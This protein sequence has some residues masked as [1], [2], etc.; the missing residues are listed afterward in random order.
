MATVPIV[1]V[2]NEDVGTLI[3]GIVAKKKRGNVR[4]SANQL[5][6]AFAETKEDAYS[7][8][9]KPPKKK[10]EQNTGTKRSVQ[11][12]SDKELLSV[13]G[14]VELFDE[15][16]SQ[17]GTQ[18]Y[19]FK[20]PK[21]NAQMT[22]F[23]EESA[24]KVRM[25]QREKETEE[26]CQSSQA[27][28]TNRKTRL[29]EKRIKAKHHLRGNVHSILTESES[30][31]E[32]FSSSDEEIYAEQASNNETKCNKTSLRSSNRLQL[33]TERELY[34]DAHDGEK[35][36][37]SR[38]C[39]TSDRTLQKLKNPRMAPEELSR[40]LLK[41][42]D[43]SQKVES[44]QAIESAQKKLSETYRQCYKKWMFYLCN[45]FNILLHGLG[46]KKDLIHAFCSDKLAAQNKLVVNGFFP[47]LSI[48]SILTHICDEIIKVPHTQNPE[49][50][51]EILQ[52]YF[53]KESSSKESL[54]LVIHNIDGIS[55]RN[56]RTQ[57]ILSHL[58][59]LPHVHIIASIDH[60]NAALIWD[61]AKLSRFHW[62][63]YDVTNYASYDE[64]TSYE[65][66]LLLTGAGPGMGSHGAALALSGLV[67]VARSLTSNAR[68]VFRILTEHELEDNDDADT[69]KEDFSFTDLY[70]KCRELFLVNSELTLRAH[71]T[72]FLD[73]KLIQI[74]KGPDGGEYL[75][76]P[77]DHSTLRDYLEQHET[78]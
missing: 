12:E 62:L 75:S 38:Q 29:R 3:K 18:V 9:S 77:L 63:W 5:A 73:H 32:K 1:Y 74:R 16:V 66:S 55:L 71:L 54:F 42:R 14:A 59:E 34:F 7:L 8:T 28:N 36:S 13:V 68:G 11:D 49:D 41:H 25:K 40:A 45:N 33:P 65:G 44:I 60:I 10:N 27:D 58:A 56:S 19:S 15:N 30:S 57:S 78:H 46:S 50:Q 21:R 43:K 39:K 22:K 61:Q 67:H 69:V 6:K 20:T 47:A 2:A 35:E 53:G 17:C 24:M 31:D 23:A 64:E 76:V 37:H 26:E 48:K 51:L 4:K 70:Q 72:E 52:Q